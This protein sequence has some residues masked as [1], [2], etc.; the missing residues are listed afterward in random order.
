MISRKMRSSMAPVERSSAS[1]GHSSR[2]GAGACAISSFGKV[3][4]E[5]GS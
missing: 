1:M 3:V 5:V 2:T 4:V